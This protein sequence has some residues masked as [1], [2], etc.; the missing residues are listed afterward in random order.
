MISTPARR[1][2]G[3]RVTAAVATTLAVTLSFVLLG[4][5]GARAQNPDGTIDKPIKGAYTANSSFYQAHITASD[6]DADGLPYASLM[7]GLFA[8]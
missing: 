3:N 8:E 6:I 4:L 1:R 2:F 7:S 5:P